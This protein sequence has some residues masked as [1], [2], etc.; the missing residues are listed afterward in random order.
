MKNAIVPFFIIC[1]LL[2]SG[3]CNGERRTEKLPLRVRMVLIKIHPMLEKGNYGKA[4]G[5]LS[6]FAAKATGPEDAVHDHPEI[7]FVLGNCYTFMERLQSARDCYKR[8]ITRKPEHRGAWQNLAKTEYELDNHLQASEAFF[9]SY[10]LSGKQEPKLLYYAAVALLVANRYE[11]SLRHFR[12][13]LAAHPDAVTLKWK[14]NLVY[15]L[16]HAKKTKEALPYIVELAAG[17][18]GKKQRRWQE[19]LLQQYLALDMRKKAYGFVQSLTRQ[20]P[21]EAVWWKALAHIELQN[22]NYKKGLAAMTIYSLLSPLT[23]EEEKL[24]GD[25]YMQQGIPQ[26]AVKNYENCARKKNDKQTVL[27]LVRS[28]IDLDR[29]EL[30][31]QNLNALSAAEKDQR[32]EMLRGE[33]LYT[34][35]DYEQAAEVYK[36]AAESKGQHSSRAFLMA[37]YCDWQLGNMM[38]AKESFKQAAQSK[39]CRKEAQRALKQLD[40]IAIT[41][42]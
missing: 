2:F 6:T 26:K 18:S 25:L 4:A 21:T 11:P 16:I 27:C 29:S 22:E 15:C 40:R 38:K 9:K 14:E 13:L 10:Q 41:R 30:A 28:Y 23:R 8:T 24:L 20:A 19:I 1:A 12:S 33:I 37:G 35:K 3:P 36:Q 42:S 39:K 31:L 17:F 34:M 7:N 32:V 5:I